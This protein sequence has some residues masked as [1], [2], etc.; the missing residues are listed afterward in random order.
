MCLLTLLQPTGPDCPKSA[1]DLPLQNHPKKW[2]KLLDKIL[3]P[4]KSWP[5]PTVHGYYV[6][7]SAWMWL[8]A[9][10]AGDHVQHDLALSSA[11]LS[12]MVLEQWLLR[13]CQ[14]DLGVAYLVMSTCR[15]HVLLWQ[16]EEIVHGKWKFIDCRDSIRVKHV[17]SAYM[18]EQ[19]DVAG[20][21]LPSVGI[22]LE[23]GPWV[24]MLEATFM[25]G[26][27]LNKRELL[28]L[29]RELEI[30]KKI[31][32]CSN[33]ASRLALVLD[34]VFE[35]MPDCHAKATEACA[36]CLAGGDNE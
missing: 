20:V 2:N 32:V 1:C 35:G 30:E 22:V 21:Y 23:S 18:L 27:S 16:V 15:W 28:L 31:A 14:D 10:F 12:K 7:V 17:T 5:T 19:A 4:N 11:W 13:D 34:T 33:D 24:P 25:Q 29:S 26:V 3:D 8:L 9:Y 6:G 36:R